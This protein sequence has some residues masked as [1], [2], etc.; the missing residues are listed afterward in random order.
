M[1]KG[2]ITYPIVLLLLSII[3]FFPNLW[4]QN[5]D[6]MEARNFI[7]ARE[8]VIDG[9]W[10]I[11]TLNG[12]LRFEK[13]PFPTWLTAGIMKVT[14]NIT[15]E[16]VS[17]IPVALIS[18]M[19]IFLIYYFVKTVTKNDF[20]GFITAFISG[21]T[22]MLVKVGNENNWDIYTY[23]FALGVIL[24]WILG[25]KYKK[26]RYFVIAGISLALSLLSKGPVGIYGL[27]IPFIIAYLCIYGLENVKENK[28]WLSISILIGLVLASIWPLYMLIENKEIFLNVMKKEKNTWSSRHVKGLFFYWDYFIY[29]GIWILFTLVALK[30]SWSSER[31]KNKK[32]FNFVFLWHILIIVLLSVIKMKKKRYGI[33]IYITSSMLVGSIC[34]YYYNKSFSELFDSDKILVR[35]QNSLIWIISLGT[36]IFLIVVKIINKN[37]SVLYILFVTILFIPFYIFMYRGNKNNKVKCTIIGSGIVMILTMNSLNWVID[38]KLKN[39]KNIQYEPLKLSKVYI[40]NYNVYSDDFYVEDAWYIGKKIGDFNENIEEREFILLTRGTYEK[41]KFDNYK[42]LDKKTFRNE[43]KLVNLYQLKR[44]Q[45]IH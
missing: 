30:R 34:E 11:T 29:T 21:T 25:I 23:V 32:F 36:P 12:K 24:F 45:D 14:G 37:I 6:L 9:N 40:G 26:H 35:L 43:N 1:N 33:P 7:T 44:K 8:M 20:Q 4:V 2:K 38:K 19:L 15:D 22:F 5:A 31:I 41:E 13:P 42:V 39:Q 27:I 28:Q 10:L 3:S 17:R 16:Y 18:V